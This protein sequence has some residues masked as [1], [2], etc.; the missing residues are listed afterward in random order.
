MKYNYETHSVIALQIRFTVIAYTIKV[1]KAHKK[2]LYKEK[3]TS[4]SPFQNTQRISKNVEKIRKLLP[5]LIHYSK[6][7]VS[8]NLLFRFFQYNISLDLPKLFCRGF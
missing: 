8:V 2:A 4:S 7:P 5:D 3:Y 6:C 1:Y